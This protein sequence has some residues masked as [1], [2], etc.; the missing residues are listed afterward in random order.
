M[1]TGKA[2]IKAVPTNPPPIF[3]TKRIAVGPI[4]NLHLVP[5]DAQPLTQ[6]AT[7][8]REIGRNVWSDSHNGMMCENCKYWGGYTDG[9][10][11]WGE[12][13]N[14]R[15]VAAFGGRVAMRAHYTCNFYQEKE[16]GE[17]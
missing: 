13:I 10:I 2:K 8:N 4:N 3:D 6:Y 5:I 11:E 17:K 1:A 14:I 12:C 15:I 16:H 9:S 7:A